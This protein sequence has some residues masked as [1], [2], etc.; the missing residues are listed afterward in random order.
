MAE[1]WVVLGPQPAVGASGAESAQRLA[2]A[3]GGEI[4]KRVEECVYAWWK[5]MEARSRQYGGSNRWGCAVAVRNARQVPLQQMASPCGR[6]AGLPFRAPKTS[7]P[8]EEV[9]SPA[10]T[11]I[12]RAVLMAG[13]GQY[14]SLPVKHHQRWRNCVGGAVGGGNVRGSGWC[15]R[16]SPSREYARSVSVNAS[17]SAVG[18]NGT[19]PTPVS[20]AR[21]PSPS[22]GRR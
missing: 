5:V 20:A 17:P 14:A 9:G 15:A 4:G 3:P 1:V 6:K 21:R 13:K 22:W 2:G 16:W 11:C 18:K 12:A 10:S 7:V 19:A 8:T